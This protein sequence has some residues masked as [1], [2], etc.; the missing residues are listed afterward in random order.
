MA[1]PSAKFVNRPRIGRGPNHIRRWTGHDELYHL[2]FDVHK[3]PV[4]VR[5]PRPDGVVPDF[6]TINN[7][8]EALTKLVRKMGSTRPPDRLLRRPGQ[9]LH[10]EDFME[11]LGVSKQDIVNDVLGPFGRLTNQRFAPRLPGRENTLPFTAS[12]DIRDGRWY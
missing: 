2:G 12:K 1:G 5:V 8:A 11:A 7:T 3:D 6:R 10:A 9:R 4:A